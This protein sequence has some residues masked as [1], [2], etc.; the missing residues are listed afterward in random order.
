MALERLS[1]GGRQ[2]EGRS[3]LQCLRAHTA[4][5]IV[6]PEESDSPGLQESRA[7]G[8]GCP[9]RCFILGTDPRQQER[10]GGKRNRKGQRTCPA[11]DG[12]AHCGGQGGFISHTGS[13]EPCGMCFRTGQGSGPGAGI[14]VSLFSGSKVI[15]GCC[16]CTSGLAHTWC[17]HPCLQVSHARKQEKSTTENSCCKMGCLFVPAA[18]LA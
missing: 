16:L 18:G 15:P 2:P 6:L 13:E 12:A 8:K 1:S 14:L 4:S 10:E 5:N 7:Q 17:R 3:L 11:C 9:Y